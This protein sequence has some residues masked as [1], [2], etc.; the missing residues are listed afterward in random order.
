MTIPQS[1]YA[2]IKSYCVEELENVIPPQLTFEIYLQR[3]LDERRL[4]NQY[5]LLDEFIRLE[6]NN[7]ILDFGCG[8]GTFVAYLQHNGFSAD[9]YEIDNRLYNIA[10]SLRTRKKKGSYYYTLDGKIPTENAKYD[11][12]FSHF[13]LE[14]VDN[15]Q[16]YISEGLRVLKPNGKFLIATCNYKL[17]YEFHYAMWLPL[18]S[19]NLSKWVLSKRKRNTKFFDSLSLITPQKVEKILHYNYRINP[20]FKVENIGKQTFIT[21]AIEPQRHNEKFTKAAKVLN[22]VGGLKIM[23]RFGF[24]NPL[25]YLITKNKW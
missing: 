3:L 20:N 15:L 10:K 24:Y 21:Q 8:I 14:H 13:V 1:T 4:E 17:G 25:I 2:K 18:F 6:K 23:Q 9:G 5:K 19:R 11:V 22:R 16:R 12:V 7:R